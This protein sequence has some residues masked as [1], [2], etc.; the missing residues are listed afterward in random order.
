MRLERLE[1][2]INFINIISDINASAMV[3]VQ[4]QHLLEDHPEDEGILSQEA[5][6][7]EGLYKQVSFVGIFAALSSALELGIISN[8]GTFSME[9]V[10]NDY[11]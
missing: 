6:M 9:E 11:K 7:M 2:F 1:P 3:A 10:N 8:P 4:Q 5:E